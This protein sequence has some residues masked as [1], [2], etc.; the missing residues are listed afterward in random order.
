MI[1]DQRGLTLMDIIT[2]IDSPITANDLAETTPNTNDHF[3]DS[4]DPS[5]YDKINVNTSISLN[6][7]VYSKSYEII[8]EPI[9]YKYY[10][11]EM[12]HKT[13]ILTRGIKG[14]HITDS[15]RYGQHLDESFIGYSLTFNAGKNWLYTNNIDAEM[16]LLRYPTY[17]PVLA[18]PISAE[19]LNSIF[20]VVQPENVTNIHTTDPI[21]NISNDYLANSDVELVALIQSIANQIAVDDNNTLNGNLIIQDTQNSSSSISNTTEITVV[22]FSSDSL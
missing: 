14:I 19:V 17:D 21:Y 9:K 10:F 4:H 7:K 22:V 5:L 13:P 2:H 20:Q 1:I 11:L 8:V 12:W 15:S 18:V 3:D 16:M 6:S